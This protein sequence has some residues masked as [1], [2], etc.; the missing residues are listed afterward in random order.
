MLVVISIHL[1]CN[2]SNLVDFFSFIS[3]KCLFENL[4]IPYYVSLPQQVSEARSLDRDVVE[5]GLIFAGFAVKNSS[6]FVIV[7]NYLFLYPECKIN[8]LSCDINLEIVCQQV[9]NCPIRSDSATVLSELKGSSHD[10]VCDPL[11]GS[12][13]QF[14]YLVKYPR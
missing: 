1:V 12:Y 3:K 14:S 13:D 5:N 11:V 7:F 6:N 8:C 10:L 9:F 4:D 2:M